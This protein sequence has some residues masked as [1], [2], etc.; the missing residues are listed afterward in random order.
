MKMY[1]QGDVLVMQIDENEAGKELESAK[2]VDRD[3]GRVVLMYG[4]VTGHAHAISAPDAHLFDIGKGEVDRIL[5][6]T[7]PVNLSHEEHATIELPAG[8]YRVLRQREWSPG[9]I[10]Y[11]AD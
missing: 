1:R 10:R 8:V 2:T 5:K 7:S 3:N 11:V 6:L 4:E 9:E